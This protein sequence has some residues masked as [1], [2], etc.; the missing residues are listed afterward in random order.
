M[1]LGVTVL[2]CYP[3]FWFWVKEKQGNTC[4]VLSL[5][6]PKFLTDI[7]ILGRSN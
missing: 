5:L 7:F 2:L 4:L 1:Y 3:L 6:V